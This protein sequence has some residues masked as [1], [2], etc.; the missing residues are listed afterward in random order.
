MKAKAL[1]IRWHDTQYVYNPS[2]PLQSSKRVKNSC[3]L[4]LVYRPIFSADFHSIS[5]EKHRKILHP[6]AASVAGG[7]ASASGTTGGELPGGGEVGKDNEKLWRLAT[8]GGDKLIRV[9][10]FQWL[11]GHGMRR[12]VRFQRGQRGVLLAVRSL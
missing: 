10:I 4:S 5:A 6:Y 9:S 11:T 7:S 1:E 12:W 2:R 8:A 3:F